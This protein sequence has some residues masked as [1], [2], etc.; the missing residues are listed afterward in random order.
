MATQQQSKPKPQPEQE[1]EELPQPVPIGPR[2]AKGGGFYMMPATKPRNQQTDF[3]SL[4]VCK[5]DLAEALSILRAKSATDLSAIRTLR[6]ELD[7]VNLYYWWG[8][9]LQDG[10]PLWDEEERADVLRVY[11]TPESVAAGNPPRSM[12]R[13]VLR[14][15]AENF[16]L[17]EL[18]LVIDAKSGSW[19]IWWDRTCAWGYNHEPPEERDP[20]FKFMYEIFLD[21]GRAVGEVFHDKQLRSLSIITDVWEGVGE[22]LTGRLNGTETAT[23]PTK[24]VPCFHNPE[25]PLLPGEGGA[26]A[27]AGVKDGINGGSAAVGDAGGEHGAE[28]H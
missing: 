28:E 15:I 26:G 21:I 4:V 1:Q 5:R 11:P 6:F 27:G 14:F 18:D 24:G 25:T 19:D 16:D 22:W 9:L 20:E 3:T 8:T 13:A 2:T 7:D 12:F 10:G 23:V 17:G